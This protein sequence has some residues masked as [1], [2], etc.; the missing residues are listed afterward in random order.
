MDKMDFWSVLPVVVV[1]VT[2]LA[3]WFGW[4]LRGWAPPPR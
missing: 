4:Y 2:G 1:V 3:F